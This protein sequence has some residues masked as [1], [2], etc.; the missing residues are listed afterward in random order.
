MPLHT[1]DVGDANDAVNAMARDS[2]SLRT[3]I[4]LVFLSNAKIFLGDEFGIV[5][6]R[7]VSVAHWS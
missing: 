6:P 4:S 1:Q 2:V 3:K 7:L 5:Y